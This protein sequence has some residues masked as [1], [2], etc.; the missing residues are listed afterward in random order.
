MKIEGLTHWSIPVNDLDESEKFYRDILGM[1]HKGRLGNS[2][3]T[4]FDAGGTNLLLCERKD[5]VV[6]T[7][8]QD[9]RVHHSFTVSPEDWENAAKLFKEKGV[10]IDHL[11]YREK[12]FFTGRELYFL[13]PSGN[14][15]EVRDPTW[16]PGMPKPTFEELAAR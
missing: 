2:S 6:R 14:L 12:G 9:G 3:M 13:D 16:K 4:C 10:E 11:E 7:P 15:L 5:K 1:E 8:E